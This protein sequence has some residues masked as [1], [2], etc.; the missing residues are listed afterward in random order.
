MMIPSNL[1]KSVGFPRKTAHVSDS[2]VKHCAE[3]AEIE[4]E[5]QK[6]EEHSR[7]IIAAFKRKQGDEH[8]QTLDATG[9]LAVILRHRGKLQEAA[10][11]ARTSIDGRERVIGK[12]HPWTWPPVSHWGYILTLQG[13]HT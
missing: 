13:E 7:K 8:P 1:R 9:G 5:Y 2:P 3:V 4:G 6:A 10:K 11:A 12:N